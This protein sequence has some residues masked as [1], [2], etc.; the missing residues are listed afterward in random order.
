MNSILKNKDN[1]NFSIRTYSSTDYPTLVSWW[2]H[3]KWP[4]VPEDFL[5]TEGYIACN[6]DKPVAAVFTYK[7]NSK[8][9]L[10]EWLVSDPAS[11]KEVRDKLISDLIEF[12]ALTVQN[13]GFRY[14]YSCIQLPK[15]IERLKTH[16]F[17]LADKDMCNMIRRLY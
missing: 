8:V 14:I 2:N 12:V 17:Q 1:P 5:P 16:G 6:E 9:V 4:G 3:Y 10:M 15:L 7:T 11:D 13:Q